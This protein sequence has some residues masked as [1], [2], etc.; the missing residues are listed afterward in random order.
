MQFFINK[1][2]GFLSPPPQQEGLVKVLLPIAAKFLQ[3]QVE[4]GGLERSQRLFLPHLSCLCIGP[5][6]SYSLPA[7]GVVA[8]H[9]ALRSRCASC[10]G[11]LFSACSSQGRG[12]GICFQP[13]TLFRPD[14]GAPFPF[15]TQPSLPSQV[16][17]PVRHVTVSFSL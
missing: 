6:A 4:M 11:L 12:P 13:G 7:A 1:T 14:V 8:R 9:A 10:P 3:D 5:C 2:S 16:A 17:L 15:R